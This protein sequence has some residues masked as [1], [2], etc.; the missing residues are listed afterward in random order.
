M[1]S[2]LWRY[3]GCPES[4]KEFHDFCNKSLG[5]I[6]FGTKACEHCYKAYC[7]GRKSKEN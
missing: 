3:S 4:D 5:C 7:A 2:E 6:C 1:K